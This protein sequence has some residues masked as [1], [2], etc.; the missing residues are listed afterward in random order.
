MHAHYIKCKE[1]GYL[2]HEII[3]KQLFDRIG[4]VVCLGENCN[5]K[6]DNELVKG[7]LKKGDDNFNDLVEENKLEWSKNG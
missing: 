3:V 5:R 2:N 1:C 6:F 4:G 7:F